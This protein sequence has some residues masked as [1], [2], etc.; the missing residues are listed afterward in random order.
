M[1]VKMV[2]VYTQ[3]DSKILVVVAVTTFK[4]VIVVVVVGESGG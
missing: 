2:M 1:M 3:G 4:V